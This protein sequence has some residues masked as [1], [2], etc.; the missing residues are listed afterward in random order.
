MIRRIVVLGLAL[1]VL[2]GVS[3]VP[4]PAQSNSCTGTVLFWFPAPPPP[5]GAYDC[6][7]TGP[8][9]GICTVRTNNCAPP[10]A[11]DE[12]AC[13]ACAAA[14]AASAGKPI[15]L[16]NGNT[17][18]IQTDVQVP[19]LGG[20]LSLTRTWNSRWPSTQSVF[21]DKGMFGLNWRSTYE[22][23]VFVG[24]DGYIKYARGDGSFWSFGWSSSGSGQNTYLVAAPNN[25]GA[26]LVTGSS[27]WTLTSKD[28][29]R[30]LFDNASGSLISI[31][32]RNGNT[33]QLSYD[34]AHRLVTLTDPGSRHLYFTYASPSSYLVVSITSDFGVSLSYSYD[35]QGRLTQLT[36]MDGTTV[37]FEYNAQSLITAVKDS[38]GKLL[39]S[40]T[41]DSLGRGLTSSR[42]GGVGSVT[43]T[44]SQ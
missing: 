4:A 13:A 36:Q 1:A 42:A 30:R 44:Y 12:T 29:E 2:L 31:I 22:E 33:T 23:R 14:A 28:G 7:T 17:Y 35:A 5:P 26:T 32:D 6:V 39:E 41:Y 25:A 21:I 40:H 15:N 37:S 11:A 24:T 8:W 38:E 3:S 27:Y 18:I 16:S 9:A 10:K 43:V 19:G 34:G 20:G